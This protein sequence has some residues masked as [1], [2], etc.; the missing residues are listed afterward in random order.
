M[1]RDFLCCKRVEALFPNIVVHSVNICPD[2]VRDSD[3]L[4]E[5]ELK[6]NSNYRTFIPQ[7]EEKRWKINLIYVDNYRMPDPYLTQMF[8]NVF[9]NLNK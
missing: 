4:F 2:S 8:Q 3:N 1:F 9:F 6:C 7:M 5:F